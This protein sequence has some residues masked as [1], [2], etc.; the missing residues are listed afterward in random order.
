MNN[1][2]WEEIVKFHDHECTGI[3]I[4]FKACEVIKSKINIDENIVCIIENN[5]S[6]IDEVKYIFNFDYKKGNLILREDKG[7]A[8]NL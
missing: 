6:P 1:L 2:L 3:A 7:L 4:G 8:Y 5:S